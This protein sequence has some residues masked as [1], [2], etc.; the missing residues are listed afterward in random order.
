MSHVSSIFAA[1]SDPCRLEIIETLMREGETPAGEIC[2]RFDISGPAV[3]RHLS[4]LHTAGLVNRKV[5]GKHRLYSVRPEAIRQVSD[6]TMDH[7]EFWE[8]SMNRIE[9]ALREDAR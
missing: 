3:S 9:A 1:L 6:W 8:A 4:V 7:R 5:A 2:E